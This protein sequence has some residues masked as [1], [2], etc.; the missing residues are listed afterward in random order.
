[1]AAKPN[2]FLGRLANTLLGGPVPP[3]VAAP[4]SGVQNAKGFD[5]GKI[6]RRLSALPSNTQTINQLIR[7]YGRTALARSRYLSANNPYT[8]SARET[9]KAALA[10]YGIKPSV[11]KQSPERKEQVQELWSD[12]VAYAD[13]DGIQDFYGIQDSVA[14]E[15]FDA[16]EAFVEVIE[17]KMDVSTD[18]P[19]LK[20]R[21]I[22]AEMLPFDSVIAPQVGG[23]G[24]YV[25]MGIEFNAAGERVAYH[26]LNKNPSDDAAGL[27]GYTT[28]R[29][30]ADKILHIYRP[31]RAG[32]VR[33][34]P[35][36]L[37]SMTTLAML[38]LYDDAE[39]ERKRMSAL[40]AGFVTRP[41]GD[42]S[43]LGDNPLGP[44]GED[45]E[46]PGSQYERSG[47]STSELASMEPGA[48][49]DLAEGE[50]IT[51]STPPAT[52]GGYELFQYRML[53][54]AAAGMGVP[55]A[56]MTGDLRRANYGSIR[57]G[58]VEFRRRITTIQWNTM[59]HQLCRPVWA[60]F[61][62]LSTFYGLSPWSAAEYARAR[63]NLRRVKWIPPRWEW[64]DPH[65]DLL[66]E[67][68]AVDEG[69][70][71]RSDSI[72]EQG[73]DAEETDRRILEDRKREME[74]V[75]QLDGEFLFTRGADTGVE[76]SEEPEGPSDNTP[77]G[78]NV[79]NDNNED[80]EDE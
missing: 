50:E 47:S 41:E 51:F 26:F 23:N 7:S 78:A 8:Q 46:M 9:F 3:T 33:G 43:G 53:L 4:R 66:A 80:A 39:L 13:A 55:Y 48:L 10:G 5:A 54:R 72:E 27:D 32:Q 62:D 38:D 58:L 49:V 21:L 12:W 20:L 60:R 6:G 79:N 36:T 63:R 40:F 52:D 70:K 25:V 14:G 22:P 44:P 71:S 24:N 65:K 35:H 67:K 37:S 11:L 19:P 28:R 31:I 75:R 69:F 2:G 29:I 64:V 76:A 56:S 68:L 18:V 73:Y 30:T 16:G 74:L 34:V 61:L 77:E 1:M 59:I 45:D 57:A 42:D 17:G 15:L